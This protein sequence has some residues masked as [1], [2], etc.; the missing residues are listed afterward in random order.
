MR[1]TPYDSS[2]PRPDSARTTSAPAFEALFRSRPRPRSRRCSRRSWIASVAAERHSARQVRGRSSGPRTQQPAAD[3]SWG[4]VSILR[5]FPRSPWTEL[6]DTDAM[7]LWPLAP[8]RQETDPTLQLLAAAGFPPA[9]VL[10]H[11]GPLAQQLARVATELMVTIV[12]PLT[13][14]QRIAAGQPAAVTELQDFIRILR[15]QGLSSAVP[16]VV[17]PGEIV[18][19]VGVVGL[20]GAGLNLSDVRSSGFRWYVVPI[21]GGRA[22]VRTIGSRTTVT[23]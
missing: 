12:L 11:P 3:T 7:A 13:L 9:R 2:E 15:A 20:P 10:A 14:T 17:S 4:S 21:Q 1:S 23:G 18:V 8:D 6:K 5:R 19:V 22:A 16:F